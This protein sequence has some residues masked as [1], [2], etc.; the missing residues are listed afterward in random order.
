MLRRQG[1]VGLR[2]EWTVHDLKQSLGAGR[3]DGKSSARA[4]HS[5]SSMATQLLAAGD[6]HGGKLGQEDR[7]GIHAIESQYWTGETGPG[8]FQAARS[9]R[10][11]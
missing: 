10:L 5:H 1:L 4:G 7:R 2:V 8:R 11:R 6:Q 3:I 9:G